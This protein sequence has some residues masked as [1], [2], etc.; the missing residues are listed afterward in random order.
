VIFHYGLV[1]LLASVL[2]LTLLWSAGPIPA[3]LTM[4]LTSSAGM[5]LWALWLTSREGRSEVPA[6]PETYTIIPSDLAA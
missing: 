5:A 2:H 6:P 4:P 1:G 3:F